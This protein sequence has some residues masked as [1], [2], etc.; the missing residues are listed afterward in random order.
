MIREGFSCENTMIPCSSGNRSGACL[1][2]FGSVP[3][4]NG[5]MGNEW[6]INNCR[7][8][9]VQKIVVLS[10]WCKRIIIHVAR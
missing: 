8:Y 2:I 6:L 1:R 7:Q 10:G 3:A 9:T 5:I 4:M